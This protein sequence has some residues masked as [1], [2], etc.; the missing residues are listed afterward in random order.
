MAAIGGEEVDPLVVSIDNRS[1][2]EASPSKKHATNVHIL[3]LG[4]LFIFF[5]YGA[6]QNL[7]STLNTVRTI[8]GLDLLMTQHAARAVVGSEFLT[9]V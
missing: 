5:A 2:L 6:T 1:R 4:F 7:E 8:T 9:E 3:S